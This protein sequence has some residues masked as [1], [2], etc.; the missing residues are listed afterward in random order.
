MKNDRFYVRNGVPG[1][2][3]EE[4][5]A[6]IAPFNS[7]AVYRDILPK[8]RL[9]RRDPA[10]LVQRR[11]MLRPTSRG[12][13]ETIGVA[14]LRVLGWN[15]EDILWALAQAAARQATIIALDTGEQYEPSDEAERLRR[16]VAEACQQNRK[17][18]TR[19]AY[20]AGVKAAKEARA[21]RNAAAW[22]KAREMYGKPGVTGAEVIAAT[23]LSRSQLWRKLGS[24]EE[25]QERWNKKKK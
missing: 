24:V 23:G 22:K 1:L 19:N 16:G 7:V 25:A 14:S 9:K 12:T 18:Q 15:A 10:D 4:Q 20:P 3:V 17:Q 13:P 6:L 5:D 11:E 21:K 2:S 8:T